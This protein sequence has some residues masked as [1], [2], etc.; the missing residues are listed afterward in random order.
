V[1]VQESCQDATAGGGLRH[2][3][4]FRGEASNLETL[5]G[6][7]WQKGLNGLVVLL[8]VLNPGRFP[9]SLRD[10]DACTLYNVAAC[11]YARRISLIN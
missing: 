2:V 8:A 3:K 11:N 5:G 10:G 9:I 4:L 6:S 7:H 1:C